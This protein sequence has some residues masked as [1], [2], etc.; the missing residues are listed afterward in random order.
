MRSRVRMEGQ[1]ML[2]MERIRPIPVTPSVERGI[3]AGGAPCTAFVSHP[4]Q[5]PRSTLGGWARE[6]ALY[7]CGPGLCP[8]YADRR[9]DAAAK[10]AAT[11][12][13]VVAAAF[14]AAAERAY[15]SPGQSP[16][17]HL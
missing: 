11:R 17:P 6:S 5:V 1:D 15:R 9:A 12:T 4:A 7:K 14:A 13:R 3:W 2:G 10:A 16:G 8:G